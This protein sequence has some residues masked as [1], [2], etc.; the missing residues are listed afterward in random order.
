MRRNMKDGLSKTKSSF[1]LTDAGTL[2]LLLMI[3]D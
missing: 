2:A 3:F 1:V